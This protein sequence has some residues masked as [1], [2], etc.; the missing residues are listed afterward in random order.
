[1][2][3]DEQKDLARRICGL[4]DRLHPDKPPLM[5]LHLAHWLARRIALNQ[6][7]SANSQL[8]TNDPHAWYEVD[9]E[10]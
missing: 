9:Y 2:N 3:I 6:N 8:P 1:M 5:R 10:I 7:P 4:L